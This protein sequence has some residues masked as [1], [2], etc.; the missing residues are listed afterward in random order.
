MS[1]LASIDENCKPWVDAFESGAADRTDEPP[2]L[3]E[4]RQRGLDAFARHGFPTT[5]NEE[6]KYTRTSSIT[7]ETYEIA[8]PPCQACPGDV[9]SHGFG[10]DWAARVVLVDGHFVE[11]LSTLGELPDGVT[12]MTMRNAV[13]DGA[14]E[15]RLGAIAPFDEASQACAALNTALWTDGLYV[16][17]ARGTVVEQP[18]Q[19]VAVTDAVDHA[20]SSQ[21]RNL[22]VAE[23]SSQVSVVEVFGGSSQ[24]PYFTNVV[25]EVDVAAN[26]TVRHV[27]LQR[28]REVASHV[29][30]IRARQAAS[31]N[32]IQG[33]VQTG[34]QLVRHDIETVFAGEGA[35]ATFNGLYFGRHKQHIDNHLCCDHAVPH[36]TSR[37]FYKG[38]LDDKSTAVFNGKVVVRPDAQKT[39]STQEN[40][41]LLLSEDAQVNT[42]PQLEIHA[43]DVK[44]AHGA[45]IG[46]LDADALFYLCSRG[47][48]KKAARDLLTF[49]FASDVISQLGLEQVEKRLSHWLATRFSEARN[50]EAGA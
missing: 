43:D 19:I 42:K 11:E 29:A 35:E 38:M 49:A 16:H 22:I 26:A 20:I 7:N 25:T 9:V 30:A 12:V 21:V 40:K 8:P 10:E 23:E 3:S 1:Q 50:M 34:A 44:C 4:L 36:G 5:K 17:V 2:W 45:T 33:A 15:D 13:R 37:Q 18:I 32:F 24:H 47:I 28:E 14:L 41:N 46:Q 39:D 31:S 48:S 6:W 27:K